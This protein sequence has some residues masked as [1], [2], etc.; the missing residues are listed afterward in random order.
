M[1][2]DLTDRDYKENLINYM[3]ND[4]EKDFIR[5]CEENGE[6]NLNHI[7]IDILLLKHEGDAGMVAIDLKEVLKDI[8][9]EDDS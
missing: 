4:E 6:I 7:Y 3:E 8:D 5:C 2:D 1:S 9:I